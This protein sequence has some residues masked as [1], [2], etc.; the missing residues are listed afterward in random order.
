MKSFTAWISDMANSIE[1]KSTVKQDDT[2][3]NKLTKLQVRMLVADLVVPNPTTYNTVDAWMNVF[4]V[5][6]DHE[7]QHISVLEYKDILSDELYTSYLYA[8]TDLECI[9]WLAVF[10]ELINKGEI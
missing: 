9:R 7:Q 2:R 8:H 6:Y 1:D 5:D 4:L 3:N 10:K